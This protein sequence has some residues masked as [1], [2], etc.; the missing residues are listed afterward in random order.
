M[1]FGRSMSAL[2]LVVTMLF[3]SGCATENSGSSPI[4]KPLPV[5]EAYTPA[6]QRQA[7]EELAGCPC[8]MLRR[9]IRDYEALWAKVSVAEAA[10]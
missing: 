8:P 2:P 7:S 9:F 10:R 6:E 4:P 1:I 5:I 3:F